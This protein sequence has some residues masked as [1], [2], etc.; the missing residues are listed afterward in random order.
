MS[1]EMS[2]GDFLESIKLIANQSILPGLISEQ[3]ILENC[4]IKSRHL[5]LSDVQQDWMSDSTDIHI[6]WSNW[7][8]RKFKRNPQF[9]WEIW[10][11]I[12][13]ELYQQLLPFSKDFQKF[14]ADYRKYR[15][16]YRI[17]LCAS[18]YT[19]EQAVASIVNQIEFGETWSA[20]FY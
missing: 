3:V 17:E 1:N 16:D 14:E 15:D 8:N 13:E 10:Y 9:T 19:L 11:E 4:P 6:T 7:T 12:P 5:Y 20:G 18:G 2:N